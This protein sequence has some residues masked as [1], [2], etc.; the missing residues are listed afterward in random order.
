MIVSLP[1]HPAI[2]TQPYFRGGQWVDSDVVE[3]VKLV[4]DLQ[5]Q[6][7]GTRRVGYHF[8]LG[9]DEAAAAA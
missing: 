4:L 7:D 5:D 3:A 6:R 9:R 8:F 1:A 2:T